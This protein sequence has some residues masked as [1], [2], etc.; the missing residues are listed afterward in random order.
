MQ[1]T[2]GSPLFF[3]LSTFALAFCLFAVVVG[4]TAAG[5]AL[6]RAL[7]H[8]TETLREPV[9]AL[10]G[11]L[12]GFMGLILAFGLSLAVGRYETRRVAVVGDANAIGTTYLR[13]QTLAE[14]M[15][16]SSL[17]L[18]R[19]YA[20]GELE[21]SETV[22]GS[23]A[24]RRSIAA[25][26]ELQR[27]LWTLAGQSLAAAPQASAPRLYVDSLNAMIDQQGV[28][29]AAL[30]NRVPTPVLMLE[31]AGSAVAMGLLSVYLAILGRGVL[32]VL[33]AATLVSSILLVTFDLDRPTRGW[34]RVPT[35]SLTQLLASMAAPP[36]AAAPP[37][38]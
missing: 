8:R 22:P 34:I 21:L 13:A 7:R 30:G 35:T 4:A 33:V 11:A 23:H 31:V 32:T 6:G 18:L 1:G 28:R 5:I 27:Q 17:A 3:G 10:Q 20:Q 38:R 26:G 2:P 37:S 19:R 14:P 24:A 9:G 29:V 12:L 25:G 16:S 15:R 36:A